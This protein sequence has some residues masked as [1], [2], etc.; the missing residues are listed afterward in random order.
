M[1]N[2]KTWQRQARTPAGALITEPKGSRAL[3]GPPGLPRCSLP[4][5]PG[6]VNH[7]HFPSWLGEHL[8]LQASLLSL[9]RDTVSEVPP[10][11]FQRG[12]A[13]ALNL[14]ALETFCAPGLTPGRSWSGWARVGQDR[15]LD[16][17]A[18][19]HHMPV[20]DAPT[21]SPHHLQLNPLL[22][23]AHSPLQGPQQLL[24]VLDLGQEHLHLWVEGGEAEVGARRQVARGGPAGDREGEGGGGG[25]RA[26]PTCLAQSSLLRL[27]PSCSSSRSRLTLS[28]SF[29]SCRPCHRCWPQS[30]PPSGGLASAPGGGGSSQLATL[31]LLP[32]P[33]F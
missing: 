12:Q 28:R 21:P 7:F 13:R 32:D 19:S 26:G 3:G 33:R 17:S 11:G 9:T 14:W 23:L 5:T 4:S 27:R 31:L 30:W 2:Q 24:G 15:C 8:N 16:L 1:T 20:P 22:G 29:C 10:P 25:G 18:S 6:P